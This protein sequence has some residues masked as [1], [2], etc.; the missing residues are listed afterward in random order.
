MALIGKCTYT[1][2]RDSGET[3]KQEML[4]E[5][6]NTIEI[7]VPVPETVTED[8]DDVYLIIKQISHFQLYNDDKLQVVHFQIAAYLTKEHRNLDQEQWLFWDNIQLDGYDYNKNVFEQC[9]NQLKNTNG[10]ENLIND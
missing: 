10:F 6:G 8:F 2:Q 7:D 3:T 4:D 1:Y 5:N 9:Y